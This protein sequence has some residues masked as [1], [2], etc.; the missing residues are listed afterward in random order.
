MKVFFFKPVKGEGQYSSIATSSGLTA[1]PG[2][3]AGFYVDI[4]LRTID[5]VENLKQSGTWPNLEYTKCS[6]YN[7]DT[8]IQRS[9]N[10]AA[11]FQVYSYS[12]Y[13]S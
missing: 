10:L 8:P 4:T 1:K 12:L 7:T 2:I 11:A 9:L 6:Q 3:E 5:A 13:Y